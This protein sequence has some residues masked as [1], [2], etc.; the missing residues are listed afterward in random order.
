MV[1]EGHQLESVVGVQ[2]LLVPEQELDLDHVLVETPERVGQPLLGLD[3]HEHPEYLAEA[4]EPA[5][6]DQPVLETG[7][8]LR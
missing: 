4:L 3:E 8:V 1:P 6:V 5:F 2:E 7:Y